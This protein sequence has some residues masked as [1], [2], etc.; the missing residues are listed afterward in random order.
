MNVIE[1]TEKARDA[2]SAAADALLAAHG[3]DYTSRSWRTLCKCGRDFGKPQGLGL[4]LS[5]VAKQADRLWDKTYDEAMDAWRA[6]EDARVR[7]GTAT[8]RRLAAGDPWKEYL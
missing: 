6:E 3:R 2:A 4:H 5:S 8:A 7:P 1:A